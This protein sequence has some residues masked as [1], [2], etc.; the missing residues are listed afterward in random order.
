MGRGGSKEQVNEGRLEWM[1]P[2]IFKGRDDD[3]KLF[4]EKKRNGSGQ[5]Y[6][7]ISRFLVECVAYITLSMFSKVI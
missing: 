2:D 6:W 7:Y 3:T 1:L 5:S 4:K